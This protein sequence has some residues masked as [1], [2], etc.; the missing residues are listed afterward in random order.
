MADAFR[1]GLRPALTGADIVKQKGLEEAGKAGYSVP[2]S[3]IKQSWLTNL[4]ERFGGKQAIEAT[5]QMKNQPITNKL[6]AKA[7]GLSD[8]TPITKEL[9]EQV[10]SDAG[11]AYEVVKGIGKVKA[12]KPYMAALDDIADKYS[13]ASKDFPELANESVLKLVKAMKKGTISA[14]GA[15]EQVKNLRYLAK[16]NYRSLNPTDRALAKAQDKTAKALD[17]LISRNAEPIIGKDA[18]TAYQKAREL[19]AKTHTIEKSLNESTGNV[20]AQALAKELKRGAPLSGELRQAAKFGQAFPRLGREPIGAPP[21]GGMLEPLVYGV[22]GGSAG[23][24]AGILAS[25][26][27]IIGKPI[28]RH[29]M[30]KV[31]KT[32]IPQSS[33]FMGNE[34]MQALARLLASFEA[35]RQ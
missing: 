1:A 14:D 32:A 6:A 26:I 24:P 8:D 16:A 31:P 34:Q 23:G 28:A 13:G 20:S 11:S 18:F 19:I 2:R 30:T 17:D 7:L 9:L 5:A 29:L 4:G 35:Q 27:P 33:S 15:L 10:R 21:S 25:G 22:A 3:N 12:D